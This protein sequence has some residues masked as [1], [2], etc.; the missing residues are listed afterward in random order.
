VGIV[1]DHSFISDKGR[2]QLGCPH[3]HV[4]Q[5]QSALLQI[6]IEAAHALGATARTADT[7][8]LS[9]DGIRF[10]GNAMAEQMS[11]LHQALRVPTTCAQERSVAEKR[12]V[13]VTP[14]LASVA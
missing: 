5:Y 6:V 13:E 7:L 12:P 3:H 10:A 1:G 2:A 11:A 9:C 14:F 4:D 8:G